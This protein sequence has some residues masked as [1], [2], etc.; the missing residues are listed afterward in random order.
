MLRGSRSGAPAAC[1]ASCMEG[2]VLVR[3]ALVLALS[4]ATGCAFTPGGPADPPEPDRAFFD[5]EI[6]PLLL[7]DCA[8]PACH[9]SR[10]RFFRVF[11]PGR[12]RL[13]PERAL[14]GPATDAEREE[15]Y[16]RA[17]SMLASVSRPEDSLLLRKPLE[18]DRG[19]APHMGIDQHGRDLY[20]SPDDP[21]YQLILE[22]ARTGSAP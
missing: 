20:A 12:A 14:G 17:R 11:G 3:I 16:H 10:D 9:A 19:G 8:F 15:A 18:V 2:G 7:R 1:T 21:A 22:W 4:V 5:E 6:Y 13:S